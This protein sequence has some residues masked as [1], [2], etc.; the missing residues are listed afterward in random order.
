MKITH[1]AILSGCLIVSL[2]VLPYNSY[3]QE[4][5]RIDLFS[6]YPALWRGRAPL[7]N[8]FLYQ[9]KINKLGFL[10]GNLTS[11]LKQDQQAYEYL[12]RYRIL[13]ITGMG[14][15]AAGFG[16]LI[17]TASVFN[18]NDKWGTVGPWVSSSMISVLLG[19]GLYERSFNHLFLAVDV[20]N[21][22]HSL[23]C[24]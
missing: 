11:I 16:G 6:S 10:G 17:A 20:Y 4:K 18:N 7:P 12:K 2:F 24:P 15:L 9:G 13:K 3:S 22:D 23:E 19:I 14:F 8:K 5:E 21:R 1:R